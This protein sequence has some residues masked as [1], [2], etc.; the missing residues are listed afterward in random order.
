MAD[1]SPLPDMPDDVPVRPRLRLIS[2]FTERSTWRPAP[3][4][5]DA[6]D[7]TVPPP[8]RPARVAGSTRMMLVGFLVIL[9]FLGGVAAQKHHDAGYLS[10]DA[11]ARITLNSTA[12][13]Q[14]N[15]APTSQVAH[16]TVPNAQ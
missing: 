12:A 10:P 8:T 13:Q 14:A 4:S 9:G 11:V 7:D 6:W 3:L 5:A 1:R 15:P 2:S 16:T